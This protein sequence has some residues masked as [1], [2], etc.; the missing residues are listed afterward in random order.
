MWAFV[1][2]ALGVPRVY[3]DDSACNVVCG[4]VWC[5]RPCEACATKH[6]KCPRRQH[7]CEATELPQQ[8]AP[9]LLPATQALMFSSQ[10]LKI[11]ATGMIDHNFDEGQ[12]LQCDG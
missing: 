8:P 7:D 10:M 9:R 6:A 11:Y 12:T 4:V 3:N 1:E 5:Q 2:G